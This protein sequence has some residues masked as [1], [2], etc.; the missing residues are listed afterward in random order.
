MGH[1]HLSVLLL[2]HSLAKQG[3]LERSVSEIACPTIV[4]GGFYPGFPS[5]VDW[6]G[7]SKMTDINPSL[8]FLTLTTRLHHMGDRVEAAASNSVS[9]ISNEGPCPHPCI[10]HLL[11]SEA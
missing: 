2:R 11:V 4:L 8:S 6:K 10:T 1:A 3:V 5:W 9:P 7:H